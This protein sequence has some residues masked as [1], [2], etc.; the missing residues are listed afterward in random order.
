VSRSLDRESAFS[1]ESVDLWSVLLILAR[2]WRGIFLA[3]AGGLLLGAAVSFLLGPTFT[4]TATILPPQQWMSSSSVMMGQLGSL[5][6]AAGLGGGLGLKSPS[7]LYIGIL[8]SRTVADQVIS[9]C[10]LKDLYK[11]PTMEDARYSLRKHVS[12]EAGKDGLIHLSVRDSDPNRASQIA[13]SYLDQLYS[14]NA[15][16]VTS[17]ASQRRGFYGQRLE[18]EKAALSEAEIA[19]RNTQQKTGL[20]QLSGQ[21]SSIINAIAQARAQLASREVELQSMRTFATAE[22][23]DTI[24]VQEEIAA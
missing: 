23:P 24:R 20:I 15:A 4:A 19:L 10:R 13:N 3:T 16:L 6:G 14:L 12:F 2:S 22:N 5:A 1:E 18:E 8:E 17:E 7:D 11:T 9:S 21:A